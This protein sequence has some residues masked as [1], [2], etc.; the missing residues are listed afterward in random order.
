MNKEQSKNLDA[1]TKKIKTKAPGTNKE[2]SKNLTHPAGSKFRLL[3]TSLFRSHTSL[4]SHS[5][6]I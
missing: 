2:Q 6:L 1:W 4:S 5:S 3:D